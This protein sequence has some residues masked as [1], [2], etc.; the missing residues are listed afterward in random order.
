MP[1]LHLIRHAWNDRTSTLA[2]LE[3]LGPHD[4][5]M[6]IEDGVYGAVSGSIAAEVLREYRP[7]LAGVLVLQ[8]DAIAR[9]LRPQDLIT[10]VENTDYAGFV[11]LSLLSDRIVSW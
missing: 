9:G 4:R 8:P 3:R 1:S 6:L 10:E 11:A 2:S 5:V 7:R